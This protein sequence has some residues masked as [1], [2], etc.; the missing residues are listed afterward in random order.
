VVKH[1]LMVEDEKMLSDS[2]CIVLRAAGFKVDLATNGLEALELCK[3]HAYDIIL[4][5]IM[6]P[7]LD[8]IGFLKRF[9]RLSLSRKPRIVILSNLSVG[10]EIEQALKLGAHK[11]IQKSE[12]EPSK[13]VTTLWSELAIKT[14]I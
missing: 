14:T 9:S 11:Y 6:M 5:D 4:L 10:N 2:Y 3:K 13:L 12:L 1:V 7:V 8:G